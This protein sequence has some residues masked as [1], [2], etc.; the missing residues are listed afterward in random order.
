[1]F[2]RINDNDKETLVSLPDPQREMAWGQIK[3]RLGT[4][5]C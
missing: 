1:M 5:Q 3:S 2:W 4:M